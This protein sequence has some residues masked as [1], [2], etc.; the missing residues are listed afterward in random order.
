M[1]N[2]VTNFT[3]VK[4]YNSEMAKSAYDKLGFVDKI[5]DHIS[6]II[7][8]GCADGSVT[9]MIRQFYDKKTVIVGYDLPEIIEAQA[10]DADNNI[11][12]TSSLE[13]IANLYDEVGGKVLLVM[14]SVVHEIYNYMSPIERRE[15]FDKLFSIIPIDYI[16]FRDMYIEDIYG[17]MNFA[18]ST[19]ISVDTI[20]EW[21]RGHY[22]NDEDPLTDKFFDFIK[23]NHYDRDECEWIPLEEF[24]HFLMK[25]RYANWDKELKEDYII[26]S[27]DNGY[28]FIN[29]MDTLD[30][31]GFYVDT[32]VSYIL[33]YINY[34]N[35]K[36]FSIDIEDN[37]H[38]STHMWALFRRG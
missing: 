14:N 38:I 10:T 5:F 37:Y 18:K 36:D 33:P 27:R 6:M 30:V 34:I 8:F 4:A 17:D 15:L 11:L 2:N 24:I 21:L 32:K 12:F 20:L 13:Y 1:N 19:R 25:C 26:L 31:Y 7:D 23:Y 3:N 16:W 29:F 28:N 22:D 35:K 9:R